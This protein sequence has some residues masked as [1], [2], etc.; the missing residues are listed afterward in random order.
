LFESELNDIINLEFADEN[1]PD[2]IKI[3]SD[4]TLMK[5]KI[6]ELKAKL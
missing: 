4:T 5:N 6:S 3:K 1:D 2:V